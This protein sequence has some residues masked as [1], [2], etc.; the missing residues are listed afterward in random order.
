MKVE[1]DP[2]LCCGYGNCVFHAEDVFEL[3]DATE[4]ARV[5]RAEVPTE[6]QPAVRAAVEDCPV[7]AIKVLEADKAS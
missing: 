4:V 1:V 2:D 6:R 7:F 5:L 3:A